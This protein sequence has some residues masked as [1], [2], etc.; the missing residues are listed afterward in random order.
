LRM[1]RVPSAYCNTGHDA[2]AA[3]GGEGLN[4]AGS[5]V[6]TGHPSADRCMVRADLPGGWSPCFSQSNS[7]GPVEQIADFAVWN[8]ASIQSVADPG[9]YRSLGTP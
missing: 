7:Q 4:V 9:F 3:T 1:I 6:A 5:C 2:S 8:I